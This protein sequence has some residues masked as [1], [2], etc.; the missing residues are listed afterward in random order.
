MEPQPHEESREEA[1]PAVQADEAPAPQTAAAGA[2]GG[3]AGEAGAAYR[4]GVA[5]WIVTHGLRGMDIPALI[6]LMVRV[7]LLRSILRRTDQWTIFSSNSSQAEKS[8]CR[9]NGAQD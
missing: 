8:K 6:F 5:A 9:Q 1:L 4:R 2:L 7:C 3:A